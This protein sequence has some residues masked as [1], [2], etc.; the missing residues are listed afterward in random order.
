MNRAEIK[1][2]NKKVIKRVRDFIKL[3]LSTQYRYRMRMGYKELANRLNAIKLLSSR[4]N[5]WTARSLYRMM[6]RQGVCIHEITAQLNK[7]GIYRHYR[8]VHF[9][10]P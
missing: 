8:S 6:Q 4:G 2:H 1:H 9:V 5:Q 3:K 7:K 10:P